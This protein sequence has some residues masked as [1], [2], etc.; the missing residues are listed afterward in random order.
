M[1]YAPETGAINRLLFLAPVSGTCVM[2][3]WDWICLLPDPVA[4]K[5]PFCP[6]KWR[7]C[8]WNDHLWFI[9]FQ[10]TFGYNNNTFI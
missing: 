3:I 7:A 2:Q 10:L 5:T 1:S 8:D 4:I 9:S 6:R